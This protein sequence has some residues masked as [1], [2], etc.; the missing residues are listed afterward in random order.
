VGDF[1]RGLEGDPRLIGALGALGKSEAPAVAP[2]VGDFFAAHSS[3]VPVHIVGLLAG[4]TFS[5]TAMQRARGKWGFNAT[6]A[7]VRVRPCHRRTK[8]WSPLSPT[9]PSGRGSGFQQGGEKRGKDQL[10]GC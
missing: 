6:H 4:E 1:F 3:V 7:G 10:Q 2:A 8:R 9:L 5:K